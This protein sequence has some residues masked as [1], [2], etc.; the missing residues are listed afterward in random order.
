MSGHARDSLPIK[1]DSLRAVTVTATIRPRMMGDTVEYNTSNIKVRPNANIEEMLGR[2]PG[3]QIYPNGNITYNGER[4]QRILVDGEDIFG[5]DPSIVTR[6]F[7]A[8]MIARVQVLDKRSDQASFTGVDDGTR[9]ETLNLILKES[10]KSGYFGKLEA[11]GDPKG[12]YDV[13]G[14]LGSFKNREQF[15]GLGLV[16]SDGALGFS[17]NTGDGQASISV[18]SLILDPLGAS[19]GT[20]IPRVAASALHYANTWDGNQEH[21]T[22]NYQYGHLLS[23]PVTSTLTEQILPDS[24]YTQSQQS[25]SINSQNQH[26]VNAVYDYIPDTLYALKLTF[27]GASQQGENQLWAAGKSD[28]NGIQVNDNVSAIQ[29][30]INNQN[31]SSDLFLRARSRKKVERVF[32]LI[33]GVAGIDNNTTGYLYSLN[34]FYLPRGSL[35]SADTTDQRKQFEMHGLSV[36]GVLDYTE[37]LWE[38]TLLALSYSLSFNDGYSLQAT[39]NKTDGK[40]QDYVDSLSSQYHEKIVVWQG[41]INLQGKYSHFHYTIGGNI[42]RS[43]YQQRDVM[44]D[45]IYRRRYIDIAPRILSVYTINSQENLSFNYGSNTREPSVDQ[46]RPAPNNNDPLHI[47][48]GNPNLRPS[49]TQNFALG[50]HWLKSVVVNVALDYSISNNGIST[51]TSIDSLGRQ[52]SQPVNTSGAQ[53]AVLNFSIN[54]RLDPWNVDAGFQASAGYTRTVNYINTALN[55]NNNYS[56]GAGISLMKYVPEK[57]NIQFNANFNYFYTQSSIN[58]AAPTH[59]WTQSHYGQISI[60]SSHSFEFGTSASYTWQQKTSVFVRSTSVMLW[61]VYAKQIFLKNRVELRLAVYNLLNQNSGINRSINT[62]VNTET[63]TNIIGRYWMFGAIYRFKRQA[64]I[65]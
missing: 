52:I 19:A 13:N 44:P 11:A 22:G 17:S 10:A 5:S 7:N 34:R 43:S 50:W 2:L 60:F 12:C 30:T 6:N 33:F 35:L 24:V 56:P 51:K 18:L 31:F 25:H 29:S 48:L 64:K 42:Y 36:N 9:A 53:N 47:V 55:L 57:Y 32:S 45:S 15:T 40:Y 58:A 37:P 28:L 38:N 59:Y 46:L 63:S 21:V 8:E 65:N 4:V 54:R 26:L 20:G 3:L 39:Y 61:N 41:S 1:T 62:N 27:G 23:Q 49:L 14:L 16:S